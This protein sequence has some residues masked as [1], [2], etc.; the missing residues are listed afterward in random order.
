MDTIWQDVRYGVRM[1]FKN[2]G[3]TAI[4]AIVLALG[5]GANTAIFSLVNALL[6][7]PLPVERPRELLSCFNK[8]TKNPNSYRAFSYPNYVDLRDRNST[9]SSLLAHSLAM[10]GITEGDDTHRVFA[11]VVSANYFHTFDIFPVLQVELSQMTYTK[12]SDF[13]HNYSECKQ[14]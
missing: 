4:A 14:K 13:K 11:D 9:F 2:P 10:V 1:L 5:I 8:N 12:Q 3:F 7:R 6:L